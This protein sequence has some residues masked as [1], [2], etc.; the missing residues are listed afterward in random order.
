MGILRF[1]RAPKVV[2]INIADFAAAHRSGCL[3]VDVREPSEF[4]RGHVAGARS[5]PLRHVAQRAAELPRDR[6]I[7]VICA[8]GHRSRV[9]ARILESS[10]LEVRSVAGGT[11]G[12][13]RQNLPLIK[14]SKSGKR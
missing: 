1:L 6:V 11:A 8:S 2:Q 14:G 12:W 10:G 13:A 7:H 4:A 3:V 5:I 9:A